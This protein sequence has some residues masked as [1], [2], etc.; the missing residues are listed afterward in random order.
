MKKN[1]KGSPEQHGQGENTAE[2]CAHKAED[3]ASADQVGENDAEVRTL[4]A[5]SDTNADKFNTNKGKVGALKGK[6]GA[7]YTEDAKNTVE[8]DAEKG[9][10]KQGSKSLP[11]YP[12]TSEGSPTLLLH[13]GR[14]RGP[15][16]VEEVGVAEGAEGKKSFTD[17][18]KLA[19]TP[20]GHRRATVQY[21]RPAS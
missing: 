5:Q 19:R 3:Y 10:P 2:A 9:E 15:D 12:S 7:T 14:V 11:A 16:S 4:E 20:L 17:T 13:S 1:E 8:C 18:E 21:P 6:S